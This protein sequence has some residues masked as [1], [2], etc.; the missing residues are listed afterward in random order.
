MTDEFEVKKSPLGQAITRDHR[1]VQVEIYED[2]AGGW[3]LEVVDEYGNSTV[4]DEAFKTDRAALEEEVVATIKKEGI[5][6]LVG[7]EPGASN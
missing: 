5:A 6:C 3:L 1:T 4:W 2:G 7:A